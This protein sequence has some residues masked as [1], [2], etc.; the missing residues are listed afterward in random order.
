[1]FIGLVFLLVIVL[2]FLWKLLDDFLED[3]FM[4][5]YVEGVNGVYDNEIIDYDVR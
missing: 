2:W 4:E 1:M 5:G 3:S